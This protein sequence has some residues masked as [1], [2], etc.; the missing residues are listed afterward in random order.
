VAGIVVE[1]K[2]LNGRGSS[3]SCA[4]CFSSA[5]QRHCNFQESRQGIAVAEN[6]Y[7]AASERARQVLRSVLPDSMW[8][9]F[10]QKGLIEYRGNR[11][12]YVISAH[13]QT[14]LRDLQTGRSMGRACLQLSIFAPEYDR[15]IA[16]YLIL[17]N[18]EDFY[19]QTANIYQ[20]GLEGITEIVLLILDTALL[21]HLLALIF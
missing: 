3:V 11:G 12:V 5:E 9:T 4:E 8:S 7:R 10:E 6:D 16:E 14:L 15:M 13:T 2:V 21:F 1:R 19:W 17:K 18:A 20:T